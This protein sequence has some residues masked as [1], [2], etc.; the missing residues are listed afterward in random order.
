MS[1]ADLPPYLTALVLD[2]GQRRILLPNT[3]VAELTSMRNLE[4]AEFAPDWFVGNMEWRGID[5]PIVSFA[6]LVGDAAEHA[7][8]SR[9]VVLNAVS[10]PDKL[11]FFALCIEDVPRSVRVDSS[12]GAD[13]QQQLGPYEEAAVSLCGE[14]LFIPRLAAVEKLLLSSLGSS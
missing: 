8:N 7:E 10:E 3:A 6:R 2:L 9:I 11:K 12:L 14:V 1:G 5:L 4:Y 13:V